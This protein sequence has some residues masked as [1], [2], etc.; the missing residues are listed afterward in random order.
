MGFMGGL[1]LTV[2][3]LAVGFCVGFFVGMVY[4]MVSVGEAVEQ[5]I[6]LALPQRPRGSRWILRAQRY[7]AP[8]ER[9]PERGE[10]SAP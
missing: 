8:I 4:E 5:A 1:L 10:E 9:A 6:P 2:L 7:R 3:L